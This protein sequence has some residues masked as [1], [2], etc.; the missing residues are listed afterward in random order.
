M[1]VDR[2]YEAGLFVWHLSATQQ[3]KVLYM[4]HTKTLRLYI[5]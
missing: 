4:R 5:W 1:S 2:S 3:L